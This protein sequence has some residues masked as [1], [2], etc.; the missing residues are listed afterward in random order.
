MILK[1]GFI[2]TNCNISKCQEIQFWKKMIISW[3]L[4]IVPLVA[5]MGGGLKIIIFMA[6]SLVCM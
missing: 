3:Q 4:F 2:L 1:W 6:A 5:K